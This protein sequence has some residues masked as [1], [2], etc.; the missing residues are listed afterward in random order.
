MPQNPRGERSPGVLRMKNVL[1]PYMSIMSPSA[2]RPALTASAA[3]SAVP[4]ITGVPAG[5]P[6]F[7]G[8]LRGDAP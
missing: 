5:R 8:G 1:L 2:A 7:P 4:V 6:A 3:A